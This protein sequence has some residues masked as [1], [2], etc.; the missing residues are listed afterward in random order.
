MKNIEMLKKEIVK[1]LRPVDPKSVILFG[2]HAYGKPDGESDIDLYVVTKDDF[3]PQ[4]YHEK[5]KIVRRISRS[6]MDLRLKV[7]LDLMVHTSPMNKKFYALRSSFAKE[8]QEKGI[9]LL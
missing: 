7:S 9:R 4:N 8:I 6:L 1:R 3:I 2:S 5:R